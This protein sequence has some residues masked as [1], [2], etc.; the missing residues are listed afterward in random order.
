MPEPQPFTR[1]FIC[2]T[3]QRSVLYAADRPRT[4]PFCSQRCQMVDLGKWLTE[5]YS[6]DR[7]LTPEDLADPDITRQLPPAAQ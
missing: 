2:P 6:I 5:A 3:C 7:D 1:S 4:Y